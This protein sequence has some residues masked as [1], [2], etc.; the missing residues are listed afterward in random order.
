MSLTRVT[1]TNGGMLGLPKHRPNGV[2]S[3][4]RVLK[5]TYN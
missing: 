3:E 1:S 4:T 2:Q 5:L